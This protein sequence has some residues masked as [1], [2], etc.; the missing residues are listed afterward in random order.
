MLRHTYTACMVCTKL[1]VVRER[2]WT[3]STYSFTLCTDYHTLYPSNVQ[4]GDTDI[5]KHGRIIPARFDVNL[6]RLGSVSSPLC[7][8]VCVCVKLGK[9][10][11]VKHNCVT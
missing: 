10:Y 7:V 4:V 3:Y 8:C 11:V 6:T 9:W 5:G 1:R 2:I